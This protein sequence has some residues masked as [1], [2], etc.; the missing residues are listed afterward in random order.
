MLFFL[1][2]FLITLL[3]R[4]QSRHELSDLPIIK[5]THFR[6]EKLLIF[7]FTVLISLISL[8]FAVLIVVCL[9]PAYIPAVCQ[10][11]VN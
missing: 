6:K 1:R 8:C 5:P 3:I 9:I 11:G 10:Y 2:Y 7:F 4:F